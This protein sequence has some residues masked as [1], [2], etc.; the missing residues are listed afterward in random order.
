MSTNLI[1][2]KNRFKAL[3]DKESRVLFKNSSWVFIANTTGT[4]YAFLRSVIIARG[5]GAETL[6][7]YT[8][9][10]AFVLTIQEILKLNV[11]MGVIRYGAQYRSAERPDKMVALIKSAVTASMLSA[12]ASVFIV[13]LMLLFFYD[14]FISTPG[15]AW[16]IFLYAIVNGLSFLD[17]I[18]KGVLNLYY[19]FRINST[20]QMIMDTIEFLMIAAC[21][22]FFSGNLQYF[23]TAVILTRLA[24]TVICNTAAMLEMRKELYPHRQSKTTLIA[25]QYKEIRGYII[26][27]SFSNTLKTMM[28]QGDVLVLSAWAGPSAVGLYAVAKKLAYSILTLT[29][30]LVKSIFPQLSMLVFEK[31]YTAL[32][33]MLRKITILTAIPSLIVIIPAIAFRE[34]I[35]QLVYGLQF[36][37]A[38]NTFIIHLLGALQGSVF[39]WTLPLMN[40]LGLTGLR[41]RI[42]LFATIAG[43]VVAWL[44]AA[45]AGAAGVASA[46]LT[47]NLII[48]GLF[49]WFTFN[50]I[51]RNEKSSAE[52]LVLN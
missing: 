27:N 47:A 4:I 10:I 43:L 30:P 3:F 44:T 48:T 39:F 37:P 31:Q 1:R 29:D 6:G 40:S 51:R 18:S 35:V 45:T 12:A 38:A 11:G 33:T 2:L 22:Y 7:H 9:A 26:G 15:L 24:N 52:N 46:L 14:K 32:K 34:T 49:L 17:N 50:F 28:N 36:A 5:L 8:V 25:D 41:F 13:G 19:K 23:F 21:I 20:V 16:F 42:Y